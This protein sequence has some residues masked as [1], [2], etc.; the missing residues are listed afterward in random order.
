MVFR[1]IPG[2]SFRKDVS[3]HL[4]QLPVT[5]MGGVR[6]ACIRRPSAPNRFRSVLTGVTQED[7]SRKNANEL[8][9]VQMAYVRTNYISE[10]MPYARIQAVTR[11]TGYVRHGRFKCTRDSGRSICTC[12][13]MNKDICEPPDRATLGNLGIPRLHCHTTT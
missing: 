5:C 2:L 9:R 6:D 8:E 13:L 7:L 1:S 12:V 3:S 4:S 10:S 11:A